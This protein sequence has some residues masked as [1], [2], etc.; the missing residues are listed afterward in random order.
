M[1][2]AGHAP[3]SD[4]VVFR[5]DVDSLEFVAFWLDN[6][7]HVLA[8]MN[9]NIWD[10]LDDIKNLIRKKTVVDLNKLIDPQASLADQIT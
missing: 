6:D 8:G 2:Y 4:R 10:V 7:N 1:E 3:N 5:G 9:V